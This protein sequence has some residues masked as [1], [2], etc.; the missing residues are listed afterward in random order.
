MAAYADHAPDLAM[1]AIAGLG[2]ALDPARITHLVVASCTGFIASG[3]DQILAR[4]MGPGA[5]VERVLIGFMGCY[6]G[7]TAL[8]TERLSVRS[9]QGAVVM[10][11]RV[12]F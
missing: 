6:A 11:G 3:I 8:S 12:P 4:R 10:V 1:Q 2:D 5:A 7:M 9:E